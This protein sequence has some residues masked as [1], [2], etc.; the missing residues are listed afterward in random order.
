MT[1]GSCR[2]ARLAIGAALAVSIGLLGVA[3]TAVATEAYATQTGEACVACHT[4]A[5]GGALNAAGDA[6]KAKAN[7]LPPPAAAT[8]TGTAA[9]SGGH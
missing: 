1:F 9:A 5:A 8:P 4:S 7:K 3:Q 6:F 2:F